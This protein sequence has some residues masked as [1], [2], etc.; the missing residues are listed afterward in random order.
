[1]VTWKGKAVPMTD[2][3]KILGV[4]YSALWSRIKK[5][6]T[7]AQAIDAALKAKLNKEWKRHRD[8]YG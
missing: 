2:L 8:M 7:D 4:S 1:M 3:C 6:M 5:G